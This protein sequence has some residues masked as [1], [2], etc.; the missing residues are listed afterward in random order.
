[1]EKGTNFNHPKKGDLTKVEPL[2]SEKDIN[3]IKRLLEN[4]PRDLAIFTIGI[5]VNL[6]ASDLCQIKVGMVKN[7]QVGDSFEIIE[8]KTKKHRQITLNSSC[9][10]AIQNLLSYNANLKDE[11][12]L[13]ISKRGGFLNPITLNGLV[14]KWCKQA[15]LKGNYGS[16]TLRKTFGYMQRV[17]FGVGIAELMICFNHSS[18][19]QTLDYLCVQPEEIKSIF[20]HEI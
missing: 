17:K 16:H 3:K 9:I 13:F 14:K 1:M 7:L 11:Q 19:K 8:K 18:Q 15:K 20:L 6:R 5:N 4:K 12:P 2:K 10:K